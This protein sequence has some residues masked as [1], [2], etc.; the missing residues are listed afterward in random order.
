LTILLRL[1]TLIEGGND[2]LVRRST[3]AFI[4]AVSLI[5]LGCRKEESNN[6]LLEITVRLEKQQRQLERIDTT[7]RSVGER[8]HE[9]EARL[10]AGPAVGEGAP[11]SAGGEGKE[12]SLTSS[13]EYH[14]II[15]QIAVIQSQL[16]SLEQEVF[17]F[18]QGQEQVRKRQE[19]EAL[20][21]QGAA[22][23]AMGEPD[24]LSRRLDIL[25]KN[26]SGNIEDPL[27]RDAFAAEVEEM[28][29]RYS[30]P[31][32]AEQKRE[33]A[34]AEIVG[35]MDRI[36]DARAKKWLEEQLEAFDQAA[37]P[38]DLAARVHIALQLQR[39]REVSE[40]AQKYSIP[41]QSLRDSGLISFP[42]GGL[43][44]NQ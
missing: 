31:L 28:K 14:D 5:V 29:S 2:M 9:M 44:G 42:S 1:C 13:R 35:A 4:A 17:A 6:P 23:R 36:P 32:S 25:L 34:R 20:R 15:G 7:L 24:E 40:L 38:I 19:Q 37:N 8:L 16:I 26:F 30:I 39:M 33:Q 22:W 3:A 11:D 43:F 18:R 12:A 27:T 10:P 41:T 21:D